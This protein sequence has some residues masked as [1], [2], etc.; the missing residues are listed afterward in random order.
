[1]FDE[2]SMQ[3]GVLITCNSRKKP[4][5]YPGRAGCPGVC[6]RKRLR[7]VQVGFREDARGRR[8]TNSPSFRNR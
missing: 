1:M 6:D 7:S 2:P 5:P 4:W 8:Y 3:S